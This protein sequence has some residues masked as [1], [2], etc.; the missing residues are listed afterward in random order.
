MELPQGEDYGFWRYV[1]DAPAQL[2]ID[3]LSTDLCRI[4][5]CEPVDREVPG[6]YIPAPR[7]RLTVNGVVHEFV[8]SNDQVLQRHYSRP[9]HQQ[10]AYA[11]RPDRF[12]ALYHAARVRQC[13]RLLH[14]VTGRV[15]DVGSG[16]SLVRMA[17]PWPF[18]LHACDRDESVVAAL[19]DEGVHAVVASAEQ[20]PFPSNTFDAVY[21]GE[22]I[23]H[24]PHPEL[25]LQR[26]VQLLRP[27]GRLVVTTP[28]R[29]HLLTRA[30]GFPVVENPEHLF[31]WDV[32]E[33]LGALR[34]TGCVLERV[35]GLVLPIPVWIPGRGWRDL[36]A[37]ALRRVPLSK[38][39]GVR[40]L[41]LG[42]RVPSLALDL[43]A[44]ARR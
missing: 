37:G 15:C 6:G 43:A 17:G 27:G 30:R 36:V 20:P 44:V 4:E 23:E 8:T 41:G 28:N 7:L 12:V 33:L 42:R 39:V 22:V 2:T 38:G 32:H 5:G 25:A 16:Y 10:F 3:L 14:G 31:E 26:W 34:E 18:E 1:L 35:E 40:V 11:A 29:R 13:R 19:R 21:A 9:A 24:L